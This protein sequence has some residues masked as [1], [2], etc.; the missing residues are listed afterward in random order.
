M[1]CA[2]FSRSHWKTRPSAATTCPC[3]KMYPVWEPVFRWRSRL[4]IFD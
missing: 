4:T 3:S 2:V 1:T